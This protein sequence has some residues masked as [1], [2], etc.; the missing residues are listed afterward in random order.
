MTIVGLMSGTSLDGLD[1]ALCQFDAIP[2]EGLRWR[3]LSA[4]TAP[5][6]PE[7][8]AR[9][10]A[11]DSAT[12]YEY[13]LAHVQLGHYFGR[14]VRRFLDKSSYSADAVA[15]H[16][17]T[18]FHQPQRQLTAQ[19]A[20]PDAIAA[21]TGLTVV[22][23]FRTLDV[24]LGGQGAPLVP[25]GDRMLF[26]SYEACLNLGGFCNISFDTDDGR[27]IAFDIA[28][29]NFALNELAHRE[30]LPFDDGGS[31][32]RSGTVDTALLQALDGLQYYRETYPKSLGKE[33]Y[34]EFFKPLLDANQAP[35]PVLLRTVTEHVAHQ[36]AVV[37]NRQQCHALLATG[38]GAFNRFLLERVTA[39]APECR[40][41]V[42]SAEVVNYK[43]AIVFALLGYLRLTGR[44]NCMA[45]VTGA[46]HDCSGGSVSGTGLSQK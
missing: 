46:S 39:L 17:H 38:G 9:L 34:L 43:E 37:L 16:G 12:A 29:C 33:W 31:M 28:P 20:D 22:A 26:G 1:M 14:C 21:E 13:A 24:A 36:I 23:N 45:S 25:I 41:T 18:I 6:P 27:R 7:W 10:A 32:A 15:S 35:V 3:L 5:Y 40:L 44:N 8:V 4:E 11:L 42:P 30:S 2:S 19:I